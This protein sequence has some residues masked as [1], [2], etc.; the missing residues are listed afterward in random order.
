MGAFCPGKTHAFRLFFAGLS[1]NDCVPFNAGICWPTAKGRLFM[2][3]AMLAA[4]RLDALLPWVR[5]EVVSRA[6]AQQ[7]LWAFVASFD[8][9]ASAG[10]VQVYTGQ[11]EPWRPSFSRPTTVQ[12][13]A[14]VPDAED[15][16][17]LEVLRLK[18]DDL[19]RRGFAHPTVPSAK[20][21][22]SE[23]PTGAWVTDLPSLRF[24]VRGGRRPSVKVSRLGAKD[25]RAHLAPG[26]Y[27]L[28]VDGTLPDLVL[29]L[30][31]HLLA[32]APGMVAVA[33]CAAPRASEWHERC[34]QFF[35]QTGIGRPRLYCSDSC[36]RRATDKRKYEPGRRATGRS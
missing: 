13:M 5:G 11:R 6:V 19:L 21:S 35:I 7:Q 16:D 2:P 36:Y 23:T 28:L 27:V 12:H 10:H 4:K 14:P 33:R 30:A 32:V 25:R 17:E 3:E 26:A 20:Y 29:F 8:G 9:S 31:A 22:N 34:G 24:G 18:L 15:W 1:A